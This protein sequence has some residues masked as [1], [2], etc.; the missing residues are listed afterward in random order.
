MRALAAVKVTIVLDHKD[1]G[2]R[3]LKLE[4]FFGNWGGRPMPSRPA[5]LKASKFGMGTCGINRNRLA[6]PLT[7]REGA[8]PGFARQGG[9][10]AKGLVTGKRKNARAHHSSRYGP[11]LDSA[12]IVLVQKA[13][14]TKAIGI[15]MP[16][17]AGDCYWHPQTSITVS[18]DIVNRPGLWASSR[19]T[20]LRLWVGT[21]G[22]IFFLRFIRDDE[23]KN[24]V[25]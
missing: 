3:F 10:G 8:R 20:V 22:S 13:T 16:H 18:G 12:I 17:A 11:G 21:S 4:P 5:L 25:I 2:K 9:R 6:P 24:L 19:D 15:R 14:K 23:A 1:P 7:I